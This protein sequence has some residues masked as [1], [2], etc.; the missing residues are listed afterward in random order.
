MSVRFWLLILSCAIV[1][2][3][4]L[5]GQADERE[6]IVTLTEQIRKEPTNSALYRRRG[7][8]NRTV[9][10]WDAAHSDYEQASTL[11]SKIDEI[12]FLKGRLFL[13]ANWPASAKVALDR[14]LRQHNNHVEALITRARALAKLGLSAASAGDYSRALQL[15]P[16]PQPELYIER[17]QTV[18][19]EGD[20][21]LNDAVAGLDE[22]LKKLGP[23]VTLQLAAID[24]ELRQK[25]YDAALERIDAAAAATPRKESWLARK[26]EIL[27]LAGRGA[28]AREAYRAALQALESLPAARR[29]VPATA[30]LEKNI[31]EQYEKLK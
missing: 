3:S 27:R 6:E 31:R 13:E 8:M 14:F 2:P 25:R 1:S 7:D 16:Q 15:T 9:Q 11:D 17:A 5:L 10:N 4:A 24:L 30:A 12:D 23:V 18:A 22:G 21:H 29:N 19:A 20:A 28:E 26:G